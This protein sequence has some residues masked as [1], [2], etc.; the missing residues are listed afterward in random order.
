MMPSS[1]NG[2]YPEGSPQVLWEDGERALSRG[3]RRGVDGKPTAVLTVVPV[4]EHPTPSNLARLAHEYGLKDEL[5]G[6]WAVL[7]LDLVREGGRTI[8]VL[9]DSGGDPLQ[10]ML[11]AP[12]EVGR[13]LRVA[14]SIAMAL[15]KVHQRG[16]IHKD[17]KPGNILVNCAD[18]KVRLTGFGLASRLPRERQA[19]EPP[20]VIA[21]TLAYMAPEQT[22]R[23]NRSIDSRSDLYALGVT[24]YEMLTGS[25]PFTVSDPIEWVHCHIARQPVSPAERLPGVPL[26]ISAIVM[27]C[28]AKTAE[29]RYLT[30]AGLAGDL[31]HCLADWETTGTIAPF[32]PG[33]HDIPDALHIPEKLYGR[34]AEVGRFLEAF[35]RVVA[36]GTPELVLV[37]GYSGVGKSSVVNELHR[38]LVLSQGL[39]AAGKFD[40]YQRDVPY[41]TLA[42]A[43]QSLIRGLLAKSEADLAPWRDALREALGPNGALVVDLVPELKLIVGEQPPVPELPLLDAQHRFQLVVRRFIGV[44]AR[45]EHPL[46]LFLDDLQWVDPATLG[47]FEDVLTRS[48]LQHL[49]LIGAYRDNEVTPA[50][51]LMR[52][53]AAIRSAGGRVQEIVLAPLGLEDVGRFIADALHGALDRAEPL[54]RLV[55]EKTGGN[56]FFTI[57]FLTA[58]AEEGLLAFDHG[59]ARWAWDLE[60]I[61]AK[62]FTDNVVELM[63]G[64]LSRLPEATQAALRQLACLGN[65]AAIATLS[66]VQGGS[67]AALHAALWEALRAG[68]VFRRDGAYRFLH[69]RVQEAAYALIPAEEQAAQHLRIGRLLAARTSPEAIEE[70]VFE[71][72]SQYK[73]GA[74]LITAA[75]E[76]EQVAELS[77]RAGRRAKAA[78]AYAMALAH[79]VAGEALLPEDRWERHYALGFALAL[80]RAECEFLTGEQAAAEARLAELAPRAANLP[81]LAAVTRLQV[82]LSTTLNRSDRGLEV[83]LDYL[84]RAGITLSAHP[85]PEEV[86]QEFDRMWRQIGDRPIE[87]LV[88]L[89]QMADP[90][91]CGAME[92]LTTLGP[93]CTSENL[94]SLIIG[95]M[96]N[97]S[98][99]H[100]NS[101]ASCLAYVQMVSV[102]GLSFGDYEAAYRFG[103]LSLDLV[104]KRG[105]DRYKGR[106]YMGF[107]SVAN[108]LKRHIRTGRL[109]VRQTFDAA[110]QA[111]DFNFATFSYHHLLTNLL[112]SGDPLNEVQ[113]EAETG[114]D[115]AHQA[116]V[117]LAV[118]RITGQLQLIRTLRGLTLKFGCFDDVGFNEERFERHLEADLRLAHAACWYW[119]RKL[120]A[121]VLVDDHVAAIAAAAQADRVLWTSS[122]LFERADYHFYAALA[123][124]ALG[125]TAPAAERARHLEALAGHHRRLQEWAGNCPENF[126]DRAALVGGEI[127]RLEGRELDGERLY[128][129][130]IRA[131]RANGFV[132]NEAI[133]YERASAFYR[134]RGFDQFAETYLRKARA[135]YVRWGADGKVRQL[136]RLYPHLRQ[137]E[138]APSATGMIGTAVEQLDLATVIKVL[139]AVSGEIV[140]ERLIDTLM[141]TAIEE[142]GAE[143]GLLILPRGVEQRI[144]AEATTRGD[145]VLV[146]RRDEAVAEARLPES[147]L[148]YVLRTRETVILDDAAVQ[149]LFSAD[150]YVR[151]RQARS[152][153]C[154]PLLNQA[155][156][157][158]VLYL[159]N[160]LAPGVFAPARTTM[161]KLLASQAAISLENTRL[162]RELAEREAK[163]RRLIDADIIGIFIWNLDGRILEAN[164]AFL[165]AVRYDREDLVAHGLRWTDL[166]PPEWRDRDAQAIEEVKTTGTAQPF[167]KEYFRK[168]GTR[169]P[170]LLGAASLEEGGS[171]GVAFVLDV[172]ERK[173]A[174]EALRR[175][176]AYLA[177]AQKLSRTGSFAYDPGRRKTLYWSEELF[178]M[179]RVDPQRGIPDYDETR[180]L[181]HPDDLDRVSETCLQGFREKAEFVQEYRVL[182][183]DGTVIHLHVVWHPVLGKDGEIIEYVGTAADVTERKQAEE[184]L[185]TAQAELAHVTRVATLGELTA[186]I[187]HEINQPLGAIVNSASA[188]VRWLDAHK[189]EAARRSIARVIAEGHRASEI[190]QRIHALV[191]K[192]P[193][194]KDWL[195]M[196]QTI[197]EVVALARSE[198]RRSGVTLG[199]QLSHDAPRICADRI[200]VQQVILNLMMNAMEA[201]SGAGDGPREL[202]V[203][204]ATDES[205]GVLVSVLDSGPG[206]DPKSLDH[207]F[208]AF[209]TTKPQGLGMG[210]A[211]SRSLIE[212]HGGRLWATAN[213]PCGAVFQFTL[214]IGGERAA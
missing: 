90:V 167:E 89:P 214:P 172:T 185:R 84:R 59:T 102:L 126:A 131:A 116:R 209:Y 202:V 10:R 26:A 61:Q 210:L 193:P 5:D 198:A 36:Q 30:S 77:L 37:S 44:F 3:W 49:L 33:A 19:P 117:R 159:E 189:L 123:R 204:S 127:A 14:I 69:D 118:D 186:S 23:M 155:K 136:D 109:L 192:A 70:N 48:D 56:P 97:L 71:I 119:I 13:F 65:S 157:T 9:E 128:E 25:L 41:A 58:L 75:A 6:T 148:H 103:Q 73:R 178:R 140:L 150:P 165:R 142:A 47:L 132:H 206:L 146:Q 86:R 125:H 96:V 91:A 175:S 199:T 78:T 81:D 16:L 39:F 111:G 110:Q 53:L 50:H 106:V 8:L 124:A 98:L 24:L 170:V 147:V 177:E 42:Q 95:R 176:E 74:A 196:N 54:A 38:A 112:A 168:D 144:E 113:R 17:I 67:E 212:A 101:D 120:Q 160:N 135:C 188:C 161:L 35:D 2:A 134:A 114:L 52:R 99:E 187:A 162:Y 184:A 20:E 152:V 149:G 203:R 156:L 180:R 213:E 211:I 100:G 93:W 64:K 43:L 194:R 115:F 60:G 62:G 80:Q 145:T 32:T 121:R 179:F 51:A 190:I 169:V 34:E 133:A 139:Q 137:E 68:L 130:A 40:Q 181:V 83:V 22:G 163:I 173:R 205:Q 82:E 63:L 129:Q 55:H 141:R 12:M 201:M 31:T 72:L 153:L 200:Q 27:K 197:H 158:G 88:D 207:L 21:G 94:R 143:R 164:D 46:A 174:E 151:Q 28:L 171:Q 4:A 122:A 183:H 18:G 57:Q 29:D 66:L 87:A 92:V 105:L 107:G 15:G 45:P 138:S 11:G 104:E 79:F 208:D 166:T 195:D 1:L 191:R 154:L 182:L 7:P 76:R 108:P 85:T